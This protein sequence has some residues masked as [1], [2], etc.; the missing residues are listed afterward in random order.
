MRWKPIAGLAA[1]MFAFSAAGA[2]AAET[3]HITIK[4]MKFSLAEAAAH[5]GDTIEW[6]NEDSFAHT[7]TARSKE[8][9]VTVPPGKSATMVVAKAGAVDY[10]C[11]FHPSMTARINVGN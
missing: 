9:D 8:W 5:V 6:T 10:F 1:A 2:A 3:I 11:R 7:A 4:G